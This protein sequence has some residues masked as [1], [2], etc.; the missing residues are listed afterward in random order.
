MNVS[1]KIILALLMAG[2]SC[3]LF[4]QIVID[5]DEVSQG[6]K[7]FAETLLFTVPEAATQQ[8]VWSDAYIG[9]IYPNI[10]KH[11]GF[12]LTL[13][14]TAIDMSGFKKAADTMIGDYN[15]TADLLSSIP[16]LDIPNLDFGKIPEKFIIPTASV[17]IRI[18]GFVLPFDFGLCAMMTNPSI[19][20]VKLDDPKSVYDMNQAINFNFLGFNGSID[21]LTIGGDIRY[22][23][24]EG[25]LVMPMISLGIGYTYT[26]GNFKVGTTSEETL[27]VGGVEYGVQTTTA[28]MAMGF[29]TQ[30]FYLQAQVSKSFGI[31]TPFIG[32]RALLSN[33]KTTYAWNY[34]TENNEHP[35][36]TSEDGDSGYVTADKATE[37]YDEIKNGL[38]NLKGIQPQVYLGLS[39]NAGIFQ[40]TLSGCADLRSFF[41]K[42]NYDE[43][44]YSG[45]LS[46]HIKF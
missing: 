27:K 2:L 42:V 21:Y 14:G 1:K 36:I 37:S 32:G 18:G 46:T 26:K 45:A 22:R 38:W 43:F 6:L 4:A 23:F 19:F 20:K 17:D 3:N 13:G 41:D 29:E 39:F 34:K 7:E 33:T 35:E 16:N 10:N 5:K 31:V 40:F 12:G 24:Y 25:S 9:N 30:V 11:F 28:D 44:I 15:S 8:N